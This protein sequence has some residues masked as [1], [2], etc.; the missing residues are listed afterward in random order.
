MTLVFLKYLFIFLV[1]FK[2]SIGYMSLL[3]PTWQLCLEEQSYQTLKTE[4]PPSS[5]NLSY[6]MAEMERLTRLFTSQM[7]WELS[8]TLTSNH[9]LT[10]IA[11]ANTLMSMNNASFVAE[12]ERNRK[13]QRY[14]FLLFHCN[15]KSVPNSTPKKT[16]EADLWATEFEEWLTFNRKTKQKKNFMYYNNIS[17]VRNGTDMGKHLGVC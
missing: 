17:T 8:T 10:I 4:P 2:I 3:L 12:Q 16:S 14:V 15:Q 6:E 1:H 9:L 5:S 7:H 13:L 11:L